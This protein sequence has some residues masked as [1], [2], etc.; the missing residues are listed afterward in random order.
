MLRLQLLLEILESPLHHGLPNEHP[1]KGSGNQPGAKG[2]LAER[3][4]FHERTFPLGRKRE[5]V[6]M[7]AGGV[8]DVDRE[9]SRRLIF[10]E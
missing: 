7:L 5:Y 1:S 10:R 4:A 3:R 6:V 8:L 2:P 9:P